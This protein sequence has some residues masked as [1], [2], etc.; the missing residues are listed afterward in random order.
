MLRRQVQA[1]VA[2]IPPV[3]RASAAA[4]A[5]AL[6]QQQSVW[7]K[8]ESVLL[9]APLPD[10]LDILPLIN[11]ALA[12]G[13]SVSL[14]RYVA[15]TQ[16]YIACQIENPAADLVVGAFGIREPAERCVISPLLRL[17]LALVPGVAFDLQGRRLGRG[18]G[19]YDQLLPA[20]HGTTCGV[21]FDE[22]IVSEVPLEPHD[23]SLNCILTPSRWIEVSLKQSE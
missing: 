5:C 15:K 17:D 1:E 18:R 7:I 22:Q 9:F 16:S 2:R 8:A 13:K 6:L 21:G 3:R 12:A 4:R 20:M 10:E 23:V 14:P 11:A 19:F